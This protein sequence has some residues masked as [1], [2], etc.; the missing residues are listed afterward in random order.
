MIR[1]YA[2]SILP[3][4]D[5]AC[6]DSCY[7]RSTVLRRKKADALR[8]QGDKARCIAAGLLLEYAYEKF[9]IEKTKELANAN[10]FGYVQN[11]GLFPKTMPEI[12]EGL[13]GKPEFVWTQEGHAKCFFNLSH[14]GEYVICVMA[15][16]EVGADVQRSAKVRENLLRRFFSIEE[17]ERVEVYGEGA[18]AQIWAQKEAETKLT[19][20]GIGEL[21]AGVPGNGEKERAQGNKNMQYRMWQGMLD[22]EHAWAVASCPEVTTEEPESLTPVFVDGG[23]LFYE[24]MF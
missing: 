1:L 20:R 13:R 16:Y 12:V 9:T 10:S 4:E 18:F 21:L 19:G 8:M 24:R 23:E 22:E 5:V 2:V 14:S 6:Y 7:R 3:L 11:S 15:D 17:R